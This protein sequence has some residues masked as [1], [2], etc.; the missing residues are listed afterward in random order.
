MHWNII[1]KEQSSSSVS[2][3]TLDSSEPCH[4]EVIL[5]AI[6]EKGLQNNESTF[7]IDPYENTVLFRTNNPLHETTKETHSTFQFDKVF[8]AN[9]TQEDVQKF[10]VHPIINDVLN[11]YNGTVITY[12]PSFSGKSYSLI[13]SKE[14]EGIL[15]N[16]CKTLFDTLE[17]NEET[18]GD[19]F[20]VS[21]L[22]FEIYMEKTYDLLV[23]L[24]E[25]KPLKLHRSSSK[26]DL[27]IK[28]ICPAHVGSYED[29]RSYIQAVQNVGSRMGCGD[30]TERSRSHLVFQLHV[31]QRN[32]KDDILKNSSLYLV[33]LHGAEKF[34]K[35][36]ES[37]LSQDALKKLNQSIEALKN[38][39]RS[40]SMKERDSAYS[41]KGSHSSAYRES[42][43]TEVL[44]DSL[45]G[46][47][48][49]KVILTCF[50]SNVP[51]TLSTLEFGDSIRQINNKVTDNT[52]GLNLKKKMDLFIQDMKIKDDNYVA[53]INILKAEIDSLKSLHNKSLP[54]DDEK[55]M[56]ENTKKE[57]IKL[58]L[59]L[60]S[61]TQL[62]SSSTN[63]DP[64]NRIDEEV[65]EIL[66]KRCEQI[67]QLEL[68]FDRQMNSNSKLQQELEYKKSKE[69]ALESMNVR[70]LEQIQLQ[71]REIQEL[72]TTNAIL[73]GE[74]ET[75]TKLAETRS[76]RIKSLESSVK[77]LS[78]NKSTIPSPRR[79][80]MS[81]SSG[82][83]MLHIE[84]GSEI[85]NS[86]WSA[87]TSSKPLGWGA[88]KVSSSSI[89]T[90]GSQES[91]VARPFKKGLNLHSIKVTSSTPK[92]PSSGS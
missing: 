32:R 33:D 85:S 69:E 62:L 80:S 64:N 36:T 91:F 13:G 65:S 26:M 90:T 7:K 24:P 49:T 31:E 81:S 2:L 84:E 29:L 41:A 76:E 45:G 59:Q 60:D 47:R 19:S 11:G 3:P 72:L 25:R 67:A 44:K 4:I 43:L 14:S 87:N 20:S 63:E 39:V 77:E 56:L 1:S 73:K 22:A 74:L 5:R 46:N 86:P 71:E 53:Q 57:N 50:L 23:P 35:R 12:G 48:K 51:T 61:I 54:E 52:T 34:D 16:I 66:T 68:S 30:K 58:K 42:Q 79:G 6:P 78:L 15:P 89:A 37:T 82:N 40:L 88:R 28:D 38:T 17:K 92:S 70:L 75:H 8:D 55:K 27:E 83:T 10:L 18:K 21:V 9:A